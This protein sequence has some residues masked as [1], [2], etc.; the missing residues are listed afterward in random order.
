MAFD[1]LFRFSDYVKVF[2]LP[3]DKPIKGIVSL[4][5]RLL[6]N[7]GGKP[8]NYCNGSALIQFGS[9]EDAMRAC[10]RF[11]DY[12]I[13]GKPCRLRHIHEGLNDSLLL[14]EF[15]ICKSVIRGLSAK[16]CQNVNDFVLNIITEW[17]DPEVGVELVAKVEP[18]DDG[19]V[20]TAVS[21]AANQK[22]L[23]C[24]ERHLSLESD[25]QWIDAKEYVF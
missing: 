24:A 14:Q 20:V 25:I 12:P 1:P 15:N 5:S 2:D 6:A 21:S 9:Q 8:V 19:L 10:R 18:L 11:I 3:K 22:L 17:N 4:L 7:C 13:F 23:G 16:S